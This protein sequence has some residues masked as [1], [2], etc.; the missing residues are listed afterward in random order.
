MMMLDGM[1]DEWGYGVMDRCIVGV[2]YGDWCVGHAIL[3]IKSALHPVHLSP[4][5]IR[6]L[7]PPCSS[8]T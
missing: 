4:K 5:L 1:Y 2:G 7:P 8:A 3:F 6:L